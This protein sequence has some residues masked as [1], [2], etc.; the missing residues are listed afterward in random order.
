MNTLSVTAKLEALPE[1]MDFVRSFSLS[2]SANAEQLMAI[3]M[4]VEE[5]VVNVMHYAYPKDNPGDI[6]VSCSINAEKHLKI[7]ISDSGR[8]YN[9]LS[10]PEPDITAELDDRGIGGLGIY[11]TKQMMDEVSYCYEEG[12]NILRLT[13]KLNNYDQSRK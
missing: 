8:A 13:K 11:L 4:S 6:I 9:P 12:E 1:I 5:I 2:H 3:E 10:R 7:Q